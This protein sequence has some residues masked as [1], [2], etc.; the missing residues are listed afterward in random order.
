MEFRN[1]NSILTNLLKIIK[2][3]IDQAPSLDKAE[4]IT[5][6]IIIDMN[7]DGVNATKL[8]AGIHKAIYFDLD[9]NG[10]AEKTAW[11]DAYDALL[12]LDKNGNGKIDN[13]TELFGNHSL[14]AE[15]KKSF[16]D[17]YAAL[18]A[19]D[20][21]QDGK[22]DAQDTVYAQLQIWRDMNQD[23]ISETDE[24]MS[25]AEAGII[26]IDL[27][28]QILNERDAQ[29]NLISHRG[30][31]NFADGREAIAEDIWFQVNTAQS[32]YIGEKIQI[33]AE[34]QALPNVQAF[35]NVVDLHMAMQKDKH[36][37]QLVEQYIK[38]NQ[39][40]ANNTKV[41]LEELIYQWTDAAEIDP[42]SRDP[43]KVYGHVLDA[44]KLVSLENLTGKSFSGT[45]C[46]GEKD[47]NPHGL[48]APILN[49]E[50]EKFA[51]YVHSHILLQTA[52]YQHLLMPI[53]FAI[54]NADNQDQSLNWQALAQH[55]E[56]Q[57]EQ[58]NISAA[59]EEY[60]L[61]KYFFTYSS[62]Y[63]NTLQDYFV[64]NIN[65]YY[66]LFEAEILDS[67][68]AGDETNNN[69]NGSNE[70]DIIYGKAGDDKLYGNNGNDLLNGGAG[71]DYLNGGYGNDTYVF[72]K[73][74]GQDV[75]Y[76]YETKTNIDRIVFNDIQRAE[77][78]FRQEGYHLIIQT[79]AEDSVKIQDYFYSNTYKIEVFQFADQTF[80]LEE[81]MENG[82]TLHGTE[83]ND[84][85]QY[86]Q[87]KGIVYAGAGDDVLRGADKDD[88][89]HGE[90]GD[91][92]LYGNNGNDILNGGAGNDR[93]EGGYG[94][95]TYV[96]AK[97]HGQDVIYDY[98]TKTNI[99]RIVF[100]DIQRAEAIF[101][102][103]G[104][105]LIIQTSA[106]DSVKIQDYF[107][108]NTYKIEVFQ[109]A[110][111]TFSLEELMANGLILHGTEN[112]DNYQYWQGK[113]IVYA[114]AG[115]DVL[116]GADKDDELHGE[117][118][119]DKLYGNNGNDI[120]NGGAG[121]DR[122]E[123]GYGNDTYVFAKGHGQDVIYD[124]ETK[125]NIDRIVFN[126]IQRAEA[127]FRQE[128]YHL[129]IQ[130]SAEDSVKIQDYFY[131]NTYKIEVFQFADQTF[132]LEELMANGLILHGTE[133]SDNYQYWQGKGIVYAG[134][135]DDVLRGADKDDELYGEAGDDKLYGN[136][137]N[138]ILN[139][140]AGNDY[141]NG[142]YGND[143]YVFAK[144]HGQDVIYDYETKTNIDR[145]VFN[146]IQRAE[147]I[148]RQEG[149][150]LIIQTSAED[151]VK[152]EYFF[153]D[154]AHK[155]EI[156]QFADQ[157]FSL[158]ELM[159]NGLTLHGTESNDNYQY[160][161][162]KGIVYAG[163]GDDV[164][165]GADKDDELY[166][167]A[168]DDK[169]YGNG[170]N[171]RLYGGDGTDYLYAGAG[172]D[173][174]NGGQGADR[175]HGGAGED[176][177]V[178]DVLDGGID[179]IEDFH[180]QEDKIA[181]SKSAFTALGDSISAETF[182][183][184]SQATSEEQRILFD[185]KTGSL[186][187]DADGSGAAEAQV[188]ATIRGSALNSLSHEQFVLV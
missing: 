74:H 110:D 99:D 15:G 72:A 56:A 30:T 146:D 181:L 177:F 78:I 69:L 139:G 169:L 111:Q 79:S 43:K 135:G 124:Y 161:Q 105:H 65:D 182:A 42:H 95:D 80:S 183:L 127:I 62:A 102:Q 150:H 121:N 175:L 84:S 144:G 178:F 64:Q 49:A 70:A 140:G 76:D 77:A 23:G 188:F 149:Y 89:L 163:A 38:A 92:K 47:P 1:S 61:I 106:E 107:Y 40:G 73:G 8:A 37:T 28:A 132:S 142:G 22:I 119:D 158:E 117:A 11:V 25:L 108:S 170:G 27:N 10:F 17:G 33:S 141:L 184:G 129:I 168:G 148:F 18:A 68:I 7:G 147:A 118:G 85:Y 122:L 19:Y 83:S 125:T 131:S 172:N 14:D 103:E 128:G 100:N 50:F 71:N 114:G 164:L 3:I 4:Q 166:G 35:G 145:I 45:W 39:E 58:G 91:D 130:T 81:L 154:N 134:A 54:L 26:S 13:G 59:Q 165:R 179:T 153:S 136:N 5:S 9:G 133:N 151:S 55:F 167:E 156:F 159:E 143:T 187:Y 171:D 16:A 138:D 185:S 152:I 96:F 112:S 44:R 63:Q 162:G 66:R 90:A 52:Q 176:V 157:T 41:L 31:V 36:L 29:G 113:G 123:G 75:I 115:D 137:G 34:I 174:L 180:V 2:T 93:L 104:Y 97:G 21:N 173:W 186:L 46:W 101:R 155:I 24:L 109:F 60:Q 48:A 67:S 120:L 98:E 32:K 51:Q 126:D 94:N 20:E 12:V 57:I 82:L 6:P 86:W 88:E 160:W 53:M 116:R 87:G